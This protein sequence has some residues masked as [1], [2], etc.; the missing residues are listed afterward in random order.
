MEPP[1]RD[2]VTESEE[3]GRAWGWKNRGDQHMRP[4]RYK[5]RAAPAARP[6]GYKD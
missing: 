2:L 6:E 5:A 1:N 3:Q 4:V